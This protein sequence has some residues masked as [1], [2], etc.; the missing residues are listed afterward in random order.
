MQGGSRNQS[1]STATNTEPASPS[2]T[3]HVPKSKQ[4]SHQLQRPVL[5]DAAE[6]LREDSW[7]SG[8]GSASGD[9]VDSPSPQTTPAESVPKSP[10]SVAP[11][12]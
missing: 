12:K 9:T 6:I 4:P 5:P 2:T 11:A 7:G 3:R 1:L 10:G 8:S